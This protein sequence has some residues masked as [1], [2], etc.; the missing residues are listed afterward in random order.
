[1]SKLLTRNE[2]RE[3]VFARDKNK[4]VICKNES[5]DRS[6]S[7]ESSAKRLYK[8]RRRTIYLIVILKL[9][10]RQWDVDV[11]KTKRNLKQKFKQKEQ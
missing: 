7:K 8:H 9:G 6:R 5:K 4:C 2:F 1:M 10:I 3:G 11:K